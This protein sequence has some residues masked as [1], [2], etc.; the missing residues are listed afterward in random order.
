M[1]TVGH[2]PGEDSFY[3]SFL[4]LLWDPLLRPRPPG[5]PGKQR[6][7]VDD[8]FPASCWAWGRCAILWNGNEGVILPLLTLLHWLFMNP[9]PWGAEP[10]GRCAILWIGNEGVILSLFTWLPWLPPSS[11]ARVAPSVTGS[12]WGEV[13]LGWE[14]AATVILTLKCFKSEIIREWTPRRILHYGSFCW[15]QN[16]SYARYCRATLRLYMRKTSSIAI[17]QPNPN[18]V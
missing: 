8:S 5:L 6:G 7:S 2:I 18:F 1:V 9:N 10:G 12:W 17:G 3:S 4:G 16:L 14:E 15:R 13:F 11:T